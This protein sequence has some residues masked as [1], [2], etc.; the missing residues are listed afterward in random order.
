MKKILVLIGV[1]FLMTG[2]FNNQ[3]EDLST[4]S[5]KNNIEIKIEKYSGNELLHVKNRNSKN[6]GIN[7]TV[8]YLNSEDIIINSE[9]KNIL[10]FSGNGEMV[11]KIDNVPNEYKEAKIDYDVVV[12]SYIKDYVED[13]DIGYKRTNTVS[14][15]VKNK[16]D[17]TIN[18]ISLGIVFYKNKEIVG[19]DE[20][21][22][23]DLKGGQTKIVDFFNPMNK[24]YSFLEYDN[25]KIYTNYA[26]SFDYNN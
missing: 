23:I 8:N 11:L 5:L 12:P 26:Y 6:V 25:F 15:E 17:D 2:C 20:E 4:E 22:I 14:A 19:Y 13:L 16:S 1:L 3:D 10:S 24:E 18:N 9:A 21:V 7:I